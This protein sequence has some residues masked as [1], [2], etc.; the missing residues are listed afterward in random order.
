[1]N[2]CPCLT[3]QSATVHPGTEWTPQ[4][5]GIGFCRT[6]AGGFLLGHNLGREILSGSVVE[7]VGRTGVQIRASQLNGVE[8]HYFFLRPDILSGVATVSEQAGIERVI[9]QLRTAPRVFEPKHPVAIAFSEAIAAAQPVNGLISRGMLIRLAGIALG[10]DIQDNVKADVPEDSRRRFLG[11]LEK[12]TEAE[13]YG[14][15]ITELAE[16]CHCSE[17]HFSRLFQSRFGTNLRTKQI[18]FRLE[19]AKELLRESNSKVIHIALESGF[20]HVG[21]FNMM[22]KREFGTTPSE[23]RQRALKTKVRPAKNGALLGLALPIIVGLS[24]WSAEQPLGTSDPGAIKSDPIAGK[25][26]DAVIKSIARTNAPPAST[27]LSPATAPT[28]DHTIPRPNQAIPTSKDSVPAPKQLF[29]PSGTTNGA[30]RTLLPHIFSTDPRIFSPDATN[31]SSDARNF[32]PDANK[33]SSDTNKFSPDARNNSPDA[34]K[35]SP[36]AATK[37]SETQKNSSESE[38]KSSGTSTNSP[39]ATAKIGRAHV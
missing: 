38:E 18:A 31:L 23:W 29:P 27:N 8:L 10:S 17:R 26:Y 39:D 32:S 6:S 33:L 14:H 12:M 5:E 22:F 25:L 21:H 1:M 35:L 11:L 9:A 34:S 36:D 15:S 30:V 19:R 16:I 24:G 4:Q 20:R 2:Y 3:I 37:S 28:D 7:L 13:L